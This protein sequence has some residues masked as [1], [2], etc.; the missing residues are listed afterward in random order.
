[1]TAAWPW[2]AWKTSKPDGSCSG[3]SGD[4][5]E[6]T[7]M[8]R[9]S[10]LWPPFSVLNRYNA[11]NRWKL[12]LYITV[13][14]RFTM[15]EKWKG[16]KKKFSLTFDPQRRLA[17]RRQTSPPPRLPSHNSHNFYNGSALNNHLWILFHC[18]HC[19]QSLGG[20]HLL[21]LALPWHH[22]D[23]CQLRTAQCRLDHERFKSMTLQALVEDG[24]LVQGC[25]DGGLL[26]GA[27]LPD[28]SQR[29]LNE[30]RCNY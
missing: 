29:L 24:L 15:S 16:N 19:G 11:L 20:G 3:S 28:H 23:F 13:L 8:Y 1:M 17:R 4:K 10:A 25:S 6:T 30:Q 26:T 12:D 21:N 18:S 22:F 2:T 7:V 9:D 27:I 5:T 14:F